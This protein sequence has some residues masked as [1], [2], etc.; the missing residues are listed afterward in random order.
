MYSRS[1]EYTQVQVQSRRAQLAN[2]GGMI[3]VGTGRRA[4]SNIYTSLSSTSYVFDPPA[5]AANRLCFESKAGAVFP[6]RRCSKC[7]VTLVCSVRSVFVFTKEQRREPTCWTRH[8]H[9]QTTAVDIFPQNC[10]TCNL[11]NR[12]PLP[13]TVIFEKFL[14][15]SLHSNTPTSL[16]LVFFVL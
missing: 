13:V 12:S 2:H 6:L 9:I 8:A 7:A 16:V 4:W 3:V 1:R 11:R 15:L 14:Q 10:F 5:T